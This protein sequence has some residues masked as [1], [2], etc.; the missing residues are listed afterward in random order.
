MRSVEASHQVPTRSRNYWKRSREII[1]NARRYCSPKKFEGSSSSRFMIRDRTSRTKLDLC[2][3]H[4]CASNENVSV[5]ED[6]DVPIPLWT[7]LI[8]NQD[9]DPMTVNIPSD[10]NMNNMHITE[11]VRFV[12]VEKVSTLLRMIVGLQHILVSKMLE[13]RDKLN[14][15]N[16]IIHELRHRIQKYEGNK[17]KMEMRKMDC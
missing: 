2:S 9:G 14:D 16:V 13:S 8:P 1:Y 4:D 15:S 11:H 5:I 7:F 6:D 10:V 12:N 3:S 17:T